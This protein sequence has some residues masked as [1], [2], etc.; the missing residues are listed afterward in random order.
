MVI[1]KKRK[2]K[3]NISIHP[4]SHS[5][6][7][8]HSVPIIVHSRQDATRIR[9]RFTTQRRITGEFSIEARYRVPATQ[10]RFKNIFYERTLWPRSNVISSIFA[11]SGFPRYR[12]YSPAFL[13]FW[14]GGGSSYFFFFLFFHPSARRSLLKVEKHSLFRWKSSARPMPL[15]PFLGVTRIS[16]DYRLAWNVLELIQLQR[17]LEFQ[18]R[19]PSFIANYV[20]TTLKQAIIP[21]F[22]DNIRYWEKGILLE[23]ITFPR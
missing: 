23:I 9:A 22:W 11:R 5:L 4:L 19:Y 1:K 2:E 16:P 7:E 20:R 3:K 10:K 6:P 14:H 21:R 17:L 13:W 15:I 8:F 18:Y 12:K